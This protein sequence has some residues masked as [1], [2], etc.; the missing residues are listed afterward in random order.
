ME[1]DIITSS[2]Y[3]RLGALGTNKLRRS[4]KLEAMLEAKQEGRHHQPTLRS[5][6]VKGGL[7]PAP[8]SFSLSPYIILDIR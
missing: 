1:M 7:S 6:F 3:Q 4:A 5:T 2:K 8:S